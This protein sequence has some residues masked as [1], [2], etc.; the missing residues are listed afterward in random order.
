MSMI[1]VIIYILPPLSM[2]ATQT[3]GAC[4]VEIKTCETCGGKMCTDGCADRAEDG[5]KC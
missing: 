1:L 4:G 3:C 2:E 5:C